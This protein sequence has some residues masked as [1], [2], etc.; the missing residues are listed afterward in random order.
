[1][2]TCSLSHALP[3]ESKSLGGEASS[4]TET[5]VVSEECLGQNARFV[6]SSTACNF[7]H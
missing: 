1:M 4:R 5:A 7:F 3:I 2:G 6:E